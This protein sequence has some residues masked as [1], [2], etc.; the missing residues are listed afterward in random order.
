ME[1]LHAMS[2]LNTPGGPPPTAFGPALRSPP[3]KSTFA[4]NVPISGIIDAV[5]DSHLLDKALECEFEY[6]VVGG[7]TAGLAMANRLS[8]HSTVL[9][10]E[11]GTLQE[12]NPHVEIPGLA[13]SLIGHKEFDWCYKTEPQ[14]YLGGKQV[15][16]PRGKLLGGSSTFNIMVWNR[17][18]K[19]DYDAWAEL[20][21]PGWDW[22]GL[23]P[24]FKKS[25]TFHEADFVGQRRQGVVP[26]YRINA[27][28]FNGPLQASYNVYL[29]PQI[30]A[31]QRGLK[32]LPNGIKETE[33]PNAGDSVGV[34]WVPSAINPEDQT[35]SSG[36]SAYLRPVRERTNLLVITSVHATKIVWDPTRAANDIGSYRAVGVEFEIAE[37]GR[38]TY[39][40]RGGITPVVNLPGVG[41]N[42]QD[43]ASATLSFKLRPGNYSLDDF[44]RHGGHNAF[45]DEA[46][47]MYEDK[48]VGI[49][50]QG[51]PLMSYLSPRL[52]MPDP[53]EQ[54]KGKKLVDSFCDMKGADLTDEQHKARL[55]HYEESPLIEIVCINFNTGAKPEPGASYLGV[56]ACLQHP[57]SRGRSHITT[58]DPFQH[59]SINPN[60]LAHPSDRF[61]LAKGLDTVRSILSTPAFS[62][63]AE[64]EA[65]PG[66]QAV[67]QGASTDDWEAYL[68]S[69]QVGTEFHPIGTC[70]MMP[71]DD[72]GVVSP[73]L[74]V[75]G[76]HNVRVIDMS[77][78]PLH[79]S[80][81]TQSTAYAIAEKGADI[82]R[83]KRGLETK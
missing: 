64:C 22:E 56:N 58:A 76:T 23:L 40:E 49:L 55:A 34:S 16:W 42:L 19:G 53:Q 66:I 4:N 54:K 31:L 6:I 8:E 11:A 52:L 36:E 60:Y 77:I 82:I 3:S 39:L 38:P 61:F 29:S 7:G 27:H 62:T 13:A 48:G 63:F 71:R 79:I 74:K 68:T 33:D 69:G 2:R 44:R 73:K 37:K 20:G 1:L 70:A 50:T 46:Y 83:R 47:E 80:C 43:H 24:F 26:Q 45:A 21:N 57:M 67:P 78:A 25:E 75:Y 9:V 65:K 14:K 51:A 59:P 10:L 41:E 81:H 12:G 30:A 32:Q 18:F 17:A 72:G 5:R 35:R 28:G 15:P